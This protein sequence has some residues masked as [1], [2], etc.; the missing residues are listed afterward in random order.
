MGAL[1]VAADVD[2]RA[3]GGGAE[4]IDDE[5]ADA[6]ERFLAVTDE[7]LLQRLVARETADEV[8]GDRGDAVVAAEALV[9]RLL[10]VLV[11]HRRPANQNRKNDRD[12]SSHE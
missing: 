2:A 9:E 4:L 12:E 11:C 6:S 5:L 7:K 8:V 10:H 1:H 3:A